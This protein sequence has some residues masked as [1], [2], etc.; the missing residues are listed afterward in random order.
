MR[1]R[2]D[3]SAEV[4]AEVDGP[5]LVRRHHFVRISLDQL[6]SGV[7]RHHPIDH[8]QQGVDDVLDPD[9]RHA[10]RT[11]L[12]DRLDEL[13][14]LGFGEPAGDLV[15]QQHARL[16][17]QR[18]GEFEPLAVRAGSA[19]PA[20]R[21]A[22]SSMPASSRARRRRPRR[23]PSTAGRGAERAADEHVLEHGEPLERS[24]DLR[25][26]TDPATAPRVGR[27]PGDVVPGETD[28]AACRDAGRRRSG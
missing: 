1:S 9:D 4:V 2:R 20:T 24:R 5:D 22:L 8:A 3:S 16:G 23:V 7:D 18:P 25:G 27:L 15:E 13:E 14:H 11:D 12:L 10:A 19:D 21:L 28:R 17:G 6:A 26:A